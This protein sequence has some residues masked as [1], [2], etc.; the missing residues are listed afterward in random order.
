MQ[1]NKKQGLSQLQN[2]NYLTTSR[3]SLHITQL[4]IVLIM[5]DTGWGEAKQSWSEHLM[6]DY[7]SMMHFKHENL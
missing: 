3:W 7:V 6:Y 5:I 1:F 4:G 2:I